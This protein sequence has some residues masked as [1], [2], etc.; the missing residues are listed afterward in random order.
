MKKLTRRAFYGTQTKKMR[1][2]PV[3]LMSG[4]IFITLEQ[5]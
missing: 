4:R 5:L 3:L 2:V 1:G